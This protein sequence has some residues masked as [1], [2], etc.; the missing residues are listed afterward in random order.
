MLGDLLIDHDMRRV[1]VAGWDVALTPTEYE[2]LRALA[3]GPGPVVSYDELIE[4]VWPG[5][6]IDNLDLVCNFVKQ[7]RAKLGHDA[8]DPAWILSV[9]GVDLPHA[10][11]RRR[12][13][14]PFRRGRHASEARAEAACA[15]AS[16]AVPRLRTAVRVDS[17]TDALPDSC[18]RRL[19]GLAERPRQEPAVRLA[20]PFGAGVMVLIGGIC[21]STPATLVVHLR[22]FCHA[23]AVQPGS[24][25]DGLPDD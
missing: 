9:R 12:L 16:G 17:Q 2:L 25:V 24:V 8:A 22:A 15:R 14:G 4:R 5:R 1:T 20:N 18:G 23:E 11:S 19:R 7:P 6:E 3:L 10:Q 21:R 13:I